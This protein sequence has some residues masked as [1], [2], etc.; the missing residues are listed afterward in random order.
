[1]P[2]AL[3]IVLADEAYNILTLRNIFAMLSYPLLNHYPAG[4]FD[5]WGG[6]SSEERSKNEKIIVVR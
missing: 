1:M 2:D 3:L 6:D 4:M 5:R